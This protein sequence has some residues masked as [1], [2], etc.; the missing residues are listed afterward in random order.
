MGTLWRPQAPTK[1]QRRQILCLRTSSSAERTRRRRMKR[2]HRSPSRK[3]TS[4]TLLNRISKAL[5]HLLNISM[6]KSMRAEKGSRR[7]KRQR[8]LRRKLLL[9]QILN[10]RKKK[11]R[12]SKKTKRKRVKTMKLCQSLLKHRPR[13]KSLQKQSLLRK[14]K[15]PVEHLKFQRVE[16]DFFCNKKF[17]NLHIFFRK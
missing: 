7:Q 3:S 15:R 13:E 9:S 16:I 8:K 1:R 4:E 14:L 10:R 5:F 11:W 12:T 2:N 17:K 6:R